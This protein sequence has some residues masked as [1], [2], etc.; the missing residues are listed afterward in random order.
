MTSPP[1]DNLILLSDML[2]SSGG[3][4]MEHLKDAVGR[5]GR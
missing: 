5:L 1:A 3:I 4:E 2:Q